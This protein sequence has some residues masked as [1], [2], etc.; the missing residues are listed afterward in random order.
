MDINSYIYILIILIISTLNFAN[1]QNIISSWDYD[2][3]QMYEMETL[4]NPFTYENL[5]NI[6]F[7]EMS[8]D[9]GFITIKNLKI[10][11]VSHSLYDSYLNLKT[12]FLLLTPD[13]V[14]ISFT[15][16]YTYGTV[17][18]NATLDFKIN[19][20]K[21][22]IKNNKTEQNQ[23]VEIY[24]EF[25]DTD[26]SVYDISDKF[27]AERVKYVIYKGFKKGNVLNEKILGKIDLVKHYKERLSKKA[28]FTLTTGAFLDKKNININLNR[29]IAFCEDVEGNLKNALC[30]YSGEINNEEDKIDRS[31]APLN[32]MDFLGANGSYNVFIN[33][34]LINKIIQKFS[35][36]GISEK[37]YDKNVPLKKLSYDF[38]VASLKNYFNGLDSYADALEFS[39][40]IKIS[41][42]DM[43]QTKFNVAFNIGDSQN[44]F[45]INVELNFELDFSVKKNVRINMCLK[46]VTDINV[47]ISTGSV[48]IKDKVGLISAIEESFDFENIPLCLSDDGISFR[49]YYAKINNIQVKEEGL[50]IFGDQLYQ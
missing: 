30:Y 33:N 15:F 18:S 45:S 35:S 34:N 26:F 20:I 32:N 24:G 5:K 29:F 10:S 22:K 43:K 44:I 40:N 3:V 47:S 9:Q 49:D 13:K 17:S 7:D 11:D 8:E 21:I 12:G 38:T 6:T 23:N 50:Y 16:D 48:T 27:M 36:D 42:F 41:E 2:K 37:T 28:N 14:S 19:L 39:T 31:D 46:N 25:S 4:G 1:S